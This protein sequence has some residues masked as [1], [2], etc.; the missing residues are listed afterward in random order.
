MVILII[1]ATTKIVA[2]SMEDFGFAARYEHTISRL[3][4]IR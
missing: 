2:V 3:A 4:T 1:A